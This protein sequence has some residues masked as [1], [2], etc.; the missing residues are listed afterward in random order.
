MKLMRLLMFGTIMLMANAARAQNSSKQF[1]L[2]EATISDVHAAY[3]SGTLTS[4]KLV[5]AYLDRIRACDQSGP[6]YEQATKHRRPPPTI[7]PL[8]AASKAS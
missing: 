2:D 3:K 7:P 8:L 4:V 1:H 6:A 5:Q